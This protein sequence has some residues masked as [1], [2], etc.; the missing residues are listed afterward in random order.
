L[1]DVRF[2]PIS[3][4]MQCNEFHPI[5]SPRRRASSGSGMLRPSAL[6]SEIKTWSAAQWAS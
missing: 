4:H 3:R 5:R 1:T 2:V 6:N